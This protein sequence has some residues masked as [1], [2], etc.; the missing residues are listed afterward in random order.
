MKV[1]I[2]ARD[3]KKLAEI[4]RQ[5]EKEIENIISEKSAEPDPEAV[6]EIKS[7][8]E[9]VIND[10]GQLSVKQSKVEEARKLFREIN[11]FN[12]R[13]KAKKNNL[14]TKLLSKQVRKLSKILTEVFWKIRNALLLAQLSMN[15]SE[16]SS[17]EK[18]G[19]ILV[20]LLKPRLTK[21]RNYNITNF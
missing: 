9:K 3:R 6:Q 5:S 20:L 21:H 15:I 12:K 13:G 16:K 1:K 18:L 7:A 2:L 11:L 17:N 4:R 19:T 8:K 14:S 10:I